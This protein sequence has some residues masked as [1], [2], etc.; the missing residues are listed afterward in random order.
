MNILIYIS[1]QIF[2]FF[3]WAVT[4][5]IVRA[6]LVFLVIGIFIA[7]LEPFMP[8][9][10]LNASTQFIALVFIALMISSLLIS[11]FRKK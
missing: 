9:N 6:F 2:R 10:L 7:A 1:R 4:G 3:L 5:G 11:L 8:F